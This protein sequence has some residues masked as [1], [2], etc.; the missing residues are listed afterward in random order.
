MAEPYF[1]ATGTYYEAQY[2]AARI[3][4]AKSII[5]VDIV[6]NTFDVYGTIDEVKSLVQAIER[7]ELYTIIC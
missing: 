7:Y 3:M 5:L 6:D 2:S 4:L 1:W